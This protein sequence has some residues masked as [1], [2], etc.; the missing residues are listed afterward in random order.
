MGALALSQCVTEPF[1]NSVFQSSDCVCVCVCT[2]S[3]MCL[4]GE[5]RGQLLNVFLYSQST[6]FLETG[7]LHLNL[8]VSARFSGHRAHGVCL[9]PSH[10]STGVTGA[11]SHPALIWVPQILTHSVSPALFPRNQPPSTERGPSGP[12]VSCFHSCR[13]YSSYSIWTA[14]FASAL[15]CCWHW[16]HSTIWC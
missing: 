5:A 14:G 15:P 4:H 16:H 12:S 9:L 8:T 1:C 7:S 13:L 11:R 2:G 3:P 10:P 6:I